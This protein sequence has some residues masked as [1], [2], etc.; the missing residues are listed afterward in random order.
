[1]A[2]SGLAVLPGRLTAVRERI[3][4]AC[5]GAG[6]AV[7]EVCL[8]AVSKRHPV[9]AIEAAYAAGQRD[10]GENYVQEMR[11]KLDELKVRGSCPDLR[12]RFIGH[13]QRNKAGQVVACGCAVDTLDGEKLARALDRRAA[14]AS[15]TVEVLLQVNIGRE[16]QKAGVM[17]ED[18]P[19]L[20]ELVGTLPAL[21]L[22]GLMAIPPAMVPGQGGVDDADAAREHL[23]RMRE[24]AR[25][26]SLP[27]LS[28]GMS[29]DL[30]LAIECGATM[31]RV[32]TDIFGPRP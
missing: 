29:A 20:V 16:P 25:S 23:G 6:R 17:P 26:L 19:A 22:R 2:V 32:G 4:R 28:M 31:V 12:M 14:E 24:L 3:E 1:M 8:V 21:R 9:E 30:E 7:D 10:F 13:L 5:A 11:D 15:T 18:A 27:E